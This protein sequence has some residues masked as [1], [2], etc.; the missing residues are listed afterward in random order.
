MTVKYEVTVDRGTARWRLN[1]LLHREDGPAVEHVNGDKSW[2]LDGKPHRLDGPAVVYA[3][4]YTEWRLNGL[5]HRL[6][7]PA[8][9]NADGDKEWWLNDVQLTEAEHAAQTCGC[10]GRT[11]TI[12]G[13]E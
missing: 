9:E 1:G 3:D 13:V 5:L 12:D 7:G 10:S 8:V 6:D 2:W 11:V 4:G